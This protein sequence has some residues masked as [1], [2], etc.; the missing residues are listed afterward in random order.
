MAAV[1]LVA[2]LVIAWLLEYQKLEGNFVG[3]GGGFAF[4]CF[5]SHTVL[6]FITALPPT[7]TSNNH[8]QSLPTSPPTAP[9]PTRRRAFTTLTA[10][11]STGRLASVLLMISSACGMMGP[12]KTAV[13]ARADRAATAATRAVRRAVV[14]RSTSMSA[15]SGPRRLSP[16]PV[17]SALV[18]SLVAGFLYTGVGEVGGGVRSEMLDDVEC[19]EGVRVVRDWASQFGVGAH[20][21]RCKATCP[22]LISMPPS[23]KK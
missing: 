12:T 10:T 2:F 18:R 13:M 3:G 5:C 6:G 20:P 11:K 15:G 14:N 4:A 17:A 16:S 7:N 9:S 23:N 22:P 1:C 8:L 19:G 21:W